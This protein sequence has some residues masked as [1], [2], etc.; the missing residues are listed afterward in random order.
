MQ[1][2]NGVIGVLFIVAALI[3]LP[4]PTPFVWVPYACG[5]VL[6]LLTLKPAIGEMIVRVLAIATVLLTF[7]FFWAFFLRVPELDAYWYARQEGW[8]AVSLIFGAFATIPV[9]SDFSCRLKADCPRRRAS[10]Q[11]SHAFFSVPQHV[12]P[13][14]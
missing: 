1:Y 2:V 10:P 6:S 14:N 11:R 12:R 9:L 7:Y 4:H 8:L 3:H 5:A 13:R